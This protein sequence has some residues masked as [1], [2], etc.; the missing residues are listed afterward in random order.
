MLEEFL[1]NWRRGSRGPLPQL[2]PIQLLN[3]LILIDREGPL[4]RRALAHSLQLKD[5]V[6]RGLTE[7]LA[8]SKLVSVGDSGVQ[9]SQPGK[10]SLQKLFRT[11]SIKRIMPL[12]GSDLILNNKAIG[13]HLSHAYREGMTGVAQRDAAVKAGA[14]GSITIAAL[15]GKLTIPPDNKDLARVAPKENARLRTEFNPSDQDLIIVGFGGDA[16]TAMAG[17]LAAVL[18]LQND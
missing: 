13:V 14:E 1:E 9:L 2:T 7:R 18:S 16:T 4:G 3:A 8:E 15:G 12:E 5:G 6:V 11:L 17:A 10:K